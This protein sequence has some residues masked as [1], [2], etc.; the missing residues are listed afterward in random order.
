MEYDKILHYD[1]FSSEVDKGNPVGIVLK[2][3]NLS[4]AE[5]QDIA[6]QVGFNETVFILKSDEADLKLKYFTPGHEINL[7]GHATIG[8]LFC[9]NE[10]RYI[11]GDKIINI[12]TNVGIL[13]ISFSVENSEL[14]VTMKQ[15]RPEF[16]AFE[17]DIEGLAKS[18]GISKDEIDMEKPIVYGNTGTWTLLVP[19]KS[20]KS[21][22]KMKS[23]NKAFPDIL[24]EI[25]KSSVHP[26]CIEAYDEEAFMHA[27]HFSSPYSGT[28]EDPVTGTGSGVM[29][30]YYMKYLE[31]DK[32]YIKFTVEQGTE[33][34][35]DGRVVVEVEKNSEDVEV[36]ISGT[37]VFVKEIVLD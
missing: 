1:V 17:G 13:P 22:E 35:R 10:L 3:D 2:A 36:Y 32:K 34:G 37:A 21:F 23:N 27:R 5:M 24:K 15:D 9:L 18:I 12:E 8:A 28:V 20:I 7:C 26:F 33:I 11:N 19:V 14:Y 16:K 30:A 25:P 29:G 4:E 6:K 31:K